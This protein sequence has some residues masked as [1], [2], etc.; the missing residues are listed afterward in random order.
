MLWLEYS[1][2]HGGFCSLQGISTVYESTF[3][4]LFRGYHIEKKKTTLWHQ[5]RTHT[6]ENNNLVRFTSINSILV[7]NLVLFIFDS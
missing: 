7:L 3:P 5:L 2:I 6:A 4:T 1:L